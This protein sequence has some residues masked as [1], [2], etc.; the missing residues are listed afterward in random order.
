MTRELDAAIESGARLLQLP[1]D[2]AWKASIQAN[3][4]VS[5]E[6]AAVVMEFQLPNAAEP[7]PVFRAADPE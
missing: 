2:R 1:I 5:L 3:L 7:A 6:L 4:E